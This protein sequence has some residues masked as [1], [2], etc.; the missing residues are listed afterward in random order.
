[1]D[2]GITP[3]QMLWDEYRAEHP[4]GYR[5]SRFCDLLRRWERRLPPVMGRSYDENIL[6]DSAGYSVPAV[7]NLRTGR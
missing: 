6:P 5:Y 3:H 2:V 7:V 4:D 1:M